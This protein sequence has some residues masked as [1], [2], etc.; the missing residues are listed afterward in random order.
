[1][2]VQHQEQWTLKRLAISTGLILA[3]LVAIVVAAPR[4]ASAANFTTHITLTDS[5]G[6]G[7]ESARV[8]YWISGGWSTLGYTDTS[9]ILATPVANQTYRIVIQYNKGAVDTGTPVDVT[10]YS[11]KTVSVKVLNTGQLAYQ[12]WYMGYG[13]PAW[14]NSMELLPYAYSIWNNSSYPTSNKFNLVVGDQNLVAVNVRLLDSNGNGLAGGTVDYYLNGWQSA[15]GTT[16]AGGNLVVQLSA[17]S[18]YLSMAMLYNGTRQQMNRTEL[19]ASNFTFRTAAVHVKLINA[20]GSPLDTG[21]AAYYATMW[22]A[23][24]NT[25]AGV[26][27]VQ[28]LPGSYSFAMTYNGS[29]EQKDS[30]AIGLPSTDV[31]FQTGRLSFYYSGPIS[32]Y[33]TAWLSFTKPT[34]EYLP[35]LTTF[36]FGPTPNCNLGIQI[37]AGDH[38]AKSVVVAKLTNSSGN[39]LAGGEA[40]AYVGSWR[41]VG[42]TNAQGLTC[43]AFDGKLGNTAVAMVYNGSRQ[44]VSQSQPTNSIYTFSTSN[45]TVELRD[46]N[47]TLIDTGS[48]SYYAGSW[49]AIGDTSGGKAAVQMLPGNYSFA[50]VYNG[51]RE[52]K[53][54]I[55]V[56]PGATTVTFATA[57][58]TVRLVDSHASA[59]DIGSASYY[60]GSWR[61]IGDTSGGETAVQM[62]SGNYSFAMVYNGTREQKNAVAVG[63]GATTV[64]FATVNVTVHLID[65]DGNALDTGSASYYAGSWRAIGDTS[66]GETAVQMLSGNYSFAMSYLGGRSQQ[67]GIA[68]NGGSSDVIFQTG[69]VISDSSSAT[70]YY[71]SGWKPFTQGMQLLG[72]NYTFAFNDA[73][74]NAQVTIVGG[75][76]NHIH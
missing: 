29:R 61:A 3:I 27:D 69:K 42:T 65:S 60:A 76:V 16:D 18:P 63:P 28:M 34:M 1:V 14:V 71:A 45:V 26:I 13:D 31:V 32:W 15:P 2:V 30:V 74:P 47:N 37:N 53:N 19:D 36:Y 50:M 41:T 62:L 72:A 8:L 5:T 21:S 49:R 6:A 22:R 44:Q 75:Q 11:F 48:A 57:P 33:Y 64:T 9:G 59:L 39:P 12:G 52:Q 68:I 38:L 66:G 55:A 40:S 70:N 20:D 23:L 17:D 25:S 24:G 73:T 10:N 35:G 54:A 67:N 43:A 58:V 51:T 7:I 4:P 46:S 56:G